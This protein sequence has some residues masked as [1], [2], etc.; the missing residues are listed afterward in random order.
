MEEL[1][2][3]M[4]MHTVVT[5]TGSIK[6]Q[7]QSQ[8]ESLDSPPDGAWKAKNWVGGHPMAGRAQGG[9]DAADGKL[10]QGA[11]WVLA[12][13]VGTDAAAFARVRRFVGALG[14]HVLAVPPDVHDRLVA[15]ISHLP[16]VLATELMG[17]AEATAD[18]GVEAALAMAAGG[19]RDATRV[20]ASDPE[21]WTGILRSNREAVLAAVD[22]YLERL[23][24]VR[25]AVASEDWPAVEARLA[26]GRDARERLPTKTRV[27]EEVVDLVVPVDDRPG[28]VAAIATALGEAAV[29]IE[30]LHLQHAD[31]VA[32]GAIVATVRADATE[33][34][35]AALARRGL[36]PHVERRRG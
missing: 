30:D 35:L 34:A 24:D 1:A 11:T 14:A 15:V 10:F 12:P 6:S 22:G 8:I 2:S 7:L 36:H 3:S 25:A 21:L 4:T 18:E 23:A 9:S 26:A 31:E 32:A 28:M 13:T 5:D 16:Q 19:F 33:R 17:L 29:N 27:T 20:A